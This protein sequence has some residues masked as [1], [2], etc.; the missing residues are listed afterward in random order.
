MGTV[1]AHINLVEIQ[2]SEKKKNS[3]ISAITHIGPCQLQNSYENV[4]NPQNQL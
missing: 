3:F 1:E 2:N 4:E